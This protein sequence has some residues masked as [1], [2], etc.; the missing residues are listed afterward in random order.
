DEFGRIETPVMLTNSLSVG[1][2]YEGVVRYMV[3]NLFARSGAVPCS[4]PVVAETSDAY[5][6]DMGG[7]HVRPQHAMDAIR[8]AA[9]GAVDEGCVGGGMGMSAFGFKGGIGT[10]SRV[11]EV[12]GQPGVVGALVQSN[13]GGRLTI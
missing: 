3:K 8:T 6:N 11:V 4:T 10:S 2:V 5:L 9:D 7:L 12:G 1:S 13:F